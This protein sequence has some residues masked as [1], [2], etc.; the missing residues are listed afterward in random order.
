[1]A[2]RLVRTLV[3]EMAEPGP[4]DI[5]WNAADRHIGAG[6]YFCRMDGGQRKVVFLEP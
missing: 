6:V 4:H 3:N 5:I 2:G 1:V